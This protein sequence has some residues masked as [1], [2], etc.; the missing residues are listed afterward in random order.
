MIV[1]S[2]NLQF[3]TAGPHKIQGIGAGFVPKN[4]DLEV[5]DEVIAVCFLP[6]LFSIAPTACV[7]DIWIPS[8]RFVRCSKMHKHIKRSI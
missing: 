4:L 1:L 8:S 5:V 2:L 7:H 6:L 3:E